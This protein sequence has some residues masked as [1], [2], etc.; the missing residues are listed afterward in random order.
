MEEKLVRVLLDQY[1]EKG[2]DMYALLD[3]NFFKGLPL[4]KKVELIK[5]H[6]S[7]ISSNTS[8]GLTKKDIS[9]LAF[10]AGF[11]GLVTGVTAGLAAKEATRFFTNGK[12]PVGVVA[13]AAILGAGLAAGNSYMSSHKRLAQKNDILRK[14]DQTAANPTDENALRVLTTR[15]NQVNPIANASIG[16]SAT[17]HMGRAAGSLSGVILG[18]VEPMARFLSFKKHWEGG[19]SHG[20]YSPG[21]TQDTLQHAY[22]HAY[23]TK[24]KAYNAS[25]DR[26]KNTILG[27]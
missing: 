1:K 24:E 5:Q 25:L 6:A 26:M 22:E 2:I 20:E 11:S 15:N 9:A 12:L 21:N 4:Q 23:D 16:S 17:A 3:D 19:D 27:I 8:R 10:D 7:H 14:I 13:G 18:Q